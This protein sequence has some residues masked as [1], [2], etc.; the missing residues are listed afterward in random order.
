MVSPIQIAKGHNERQCVEQPKYMVLF[1]NCWDNIAEV[2]Q[3]MPS[4]FC[5]SC[6]NVF[7]T[8]WE[9]KLLQSSVNFTTH[10]G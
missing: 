7:I 8:V 6:W 3:V 4:E 1:F 9:V 10:V 2:Q 5:S